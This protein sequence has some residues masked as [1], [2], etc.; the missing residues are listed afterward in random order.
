[1]T[2]LTSKLDFAFFFQ[3]AFFTAF[4]L[5]FGNEMLLTSLFLSGLITI[6]VRI[7]LGILPRRSWIMALIF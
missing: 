5:L 3:A 6:Q 1:M 7:R 4:V 2:W